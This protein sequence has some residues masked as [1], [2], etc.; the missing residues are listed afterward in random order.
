MC[1]NGRSD[2]ALESIE[3]ICGE[4]WGFLRAGAERFNYAY[5]A[6]WQG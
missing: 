5:E 4:D 3:Q 2:E 1:D 6:F